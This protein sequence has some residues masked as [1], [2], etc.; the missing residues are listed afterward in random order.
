MSASL[1]VTGETIQMELGYRWLNG[2]VLVWLE[3]VRD[4]LF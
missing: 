1:T 3:K 2:A 4:T